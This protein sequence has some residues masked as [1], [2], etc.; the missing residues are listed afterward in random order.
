METRTHRYEISRPQPVPPPPTRLVL[1]RPPPP[2]PPPPPPLPL[3]LLQTSLQPREVAVATTAKCAVPESTAWWSAIARPLSD[4]CEL[5][6]PS[7]I[8]RVTRKPSARIPNHRSASRASST[9]RDEAAKRAGSVKTAP[10]IAQLP[11]TRTKSQDNGS[12]SYSSTPEQSSF[13]SIPQAS[14]PR[15]S[16]SQTHAQRPGKS[17]ARIPSVHAILE[18][19][20][21]PPTNQGYSIPNRGKS[22]SP[23]KEAGRR[24][25][26]ITSEAERRVPSQ[27]HVR[28]P[29]PTDILEFSS[30]KHPRVKL[31]LQVSAPV[32]VGGGSV[33]GYVRII[34]DD[35]E[36]VRLRRSLSLGTISVDLLGFEDMANNRKSIF[37]ALGTELIDVEHPPPQK[38]VQQ[39]KNSLLSQDEFWPLEPSSSALPFM[40][41]LPLDT[42]PPPF[43]SKS[44]CIRF[45]L[46]VTAVIRDAEKL[47]R[48]RRSQEVHVLPTFDP[49]K[50][51]MSLPS[52]LTASDELAM[53]RT[54]KHESLKVTAGLH[55]QVWV[56]GCSI[57]VD[58]HISNR[59]H[60]AV[61][62]LELTLERD[63]LCYKHAAAATMEKSASQAR[64]FESNE[65]TILAKSIFKSGCI[66]WN[67]VD[68]HA[69]DTRTCELELPRGHATVRC[70]K[71]FEVR[72]FLNVMASLSNS[73]LV[74]VQLPIILIH[75]NSLDVVPNSVAQVAAAIEE[76]RKHHGRKLSRS[77]GGL[78]RQRSVSSP[79]RVA[80]LTR[81]PSYS[82]GRAFA[83]P[84]QQSL[85]R[86]RKEKAD[87]DELRHVLDSSPR[88]HRT[89]QQQPPSRLDTRNKASKFSFSTVGIGDKSTETLGMLGALSYQTPPPKQT[90]RTIDT[91]DNNTRPHHPH[92]QSVRDE[93][94]RMRS[95]DSIRSKYTVI[96]G[97]SR[98]AYAPTAQSSYRQRYH[99]APHTLG[100]TSTAGK[101]VE[102]SAPRSATA[103]GFGERSDRTRF[104]FPPVRRKT[105]GSSG[106]LRER[107]MNWWDQMRSRHR[108]T[109]EE[110]EKERELGGWI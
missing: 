83:A 89:Q 95:S 42:G 51:L 81:K 78:S 75:I 28:N 33:E 13:Y 46:C 1:P 67:G 53:S 87:I 92:I 85:D 100:L 76:K 105:S 77:H 108:D 82:Q 66:G 43:H 27:T 64:I 17:H 90:G 73:K 19:N 15:R 79:T 41:S 25:D 38:M 68:S 59:C 30:Y 10:N 31:E 3:P 21:A 16:S 18:S 37:L 23:V 36:R 72:Y 101:V 47:Y 55:R 8:D 52:P 11:H 96:A 60:K 88:K 110:V 80:Q 5:S 106:S 49:E 24:L 74:S 103:M 109:D 62:R 44:A 107:G 71:Y 22:H 40:L 29:I 7:L 4:I 20:H 57:F 9:K 50:A 35:N 99:I 14:V 104:E 26:A 6:E 56:S 54:S 102:D 45:L 39:P 12:S 63:V 34:V 93:V 98:P 32:F 94:H 58:V 2:P 61:K 70:G 65:Q 84:R 86:Q 69:S 97:R 48:I 91:T